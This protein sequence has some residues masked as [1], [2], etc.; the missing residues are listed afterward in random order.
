MVLLLLVTMETQCL[1]C[2]MLWTPT[3][4]PTRAQIASYPHMC[5]HQVGL[6]NQFCLSVSLSVQSSTSTRLANMFANFMLNATI[7]VMTFVHL[8]QVKAVRIYGLVAPPL[9]YSNDTLAV[10]M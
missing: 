10:S 2:L 8:I 4:T 5:R 3:D 7:H 6:S 9:S 1:S